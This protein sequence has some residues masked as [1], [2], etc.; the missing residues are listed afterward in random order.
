[1]LLVVVL[2][3][4][5]TIV[6]I[7]GYLLS[8]VVRILLM[9]WVLKIF[10]RF[11]WSQTLSRRS[12][13]SCAESQLLTEMLFL[14]FLEVG[15]MIFVKTSFLEALTPNVVARTFVMMLVVSLQMLMSVV[16]LSMIF[17]KL[18]LLEMLM[19]NVVEKTFA[20]EL[21][22]SMQMLMTVVV[23]PFLT[24]WVLK[25][26]LVRTVTLFLGFLGVV[27]MIFVKTSFLEALTP[28]V[29]EKSFVM[30]LLLSLQILMTAV[31]LSM[32]I[33]K[34]SFLEMLMPNVV[35]KAFVVELELSLQMLMTVVV[36]PIALIILVKSTFLEMLAPTG[37]EM[38]CQV[39]QSWSCFPSLLVAIF[40]GNR[41][42]PLLF[43]YLVAQIVWYRWRYGSQWDAAS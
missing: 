11:L 16:V 29:V 27:S 13:V 43:L 39:V 5:P 24:D 6:I 23:L 32:L 10:V 28:N 17:V 36:L 2:K 1:M 7:Q 42:V 37:V 14:G 9:S 21:E 18:S 41:V 33:V 12:P 25:I 40:V 26:F 8:L 30:A 22:M 31:V 19:P 3:V 34:T 15:S 35:E 38:T 4:V 20:V